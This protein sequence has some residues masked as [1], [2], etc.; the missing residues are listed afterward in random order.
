MKKDR[1]GQSEVGAI[2]RLIVKHARDAF[3]SP[4]TIAAEWQALNFTAPPDF[5]KAVEQYEAFLD[6]LR[7]PGCE[8]TFQPEANDVGPDSIYVRDASVVCDRGIILC[9]MGKARR[10]AEPAA[11]EAVWRALG[12]NI[13]GTIRPPGLLE[14]GDVVWLD[15]RTVA[16]GRG[17]RTNDSG[18]AQLRSFLG[19][20][21]DELITVPLPHWRGAGD[22]F[23]LM[24]I[25]SPI[26]R[27]LAVVCLPLLP[28]PFLERLMERNV[29]LVEVPDNEFETMG[30][31]V[32]A[33]APRRCVTVAGN[34]KTR[35]RLV[36]AGATV[37]EYDG[38][39]ISL[40][41][42]GGPTCLTRPFER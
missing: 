42:G 36:A 34:P 29:T 17:Y 7:G 13:I 24:S 21:V 12:C 16:V 32:L 25:V 30:A 5:Q 8:I 31:N 19:D 41:G 26:D 14:G 2:K 33:L 37:L 1:S 6:L 28:V 27:D 23:H 20:C 22:V 18:I 15:E 40:K 10:A 4:E 38:S 35:A 39:E 3:Q 9:R 11:Q